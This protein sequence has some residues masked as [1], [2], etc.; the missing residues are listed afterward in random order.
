VK[1]GLPS[2]LINPYYISF[3]KTFF[4]DLGLEVIESGKTTKKILNKGIR[5]SVPEICAPIKI[6]SGHVVEL[7]DKGADLIY[8]PRFV[9]IKKGDVFCPKFM[10]LP[11]IL[12][13]S[14]PGLEEKML[15]HH[16][17]AFDDDISSENNYLKLGLR[18][19]KD[20]KLVRKA[21][22]NGR[23]AWL[24]FRKLCLEGYNCQASNKAVLSGDRPVIHEFPI[25]IGVIGYVYNLYDDILSMDI[26]NK[27]TELGAS[28]VTFEMLSKREIDSHLRG[29]QKNLFWTFS[30]KLMAGAYH[31]LEDKSIDGLIHA[32]AFGCG[33]DSFLGKMLELDSGLFGKPIMTIRLDE[34]SGENHQQT[35]VE[36]F[37]DMISK[38]KRMGE[39]S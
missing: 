18:F 23:A 36:A 9:S 6:Y 38:K 33:P 19:T 25:K 3:W 13:F 2:A 31:F 32:T 7:L 39:S 1:I 29:K 21:I 34:H 27:L 20:R 35:R 10:A 26:L 14:I 5:F 37:V 8:I 24:K 22:M 15:T 12:K 16:I 30:N 4:Q 28:S 11:D 17:N